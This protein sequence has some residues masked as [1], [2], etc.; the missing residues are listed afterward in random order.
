MSKANMNN[1]ENPLL[2][3]YMDEAEYCRQRGIS[4][5]TAQRERRL[6]VGPPFVPLG[7]RTF[8]RMEAVQAWMREQEIDPKRLR[9]GRR[10]R[11]RS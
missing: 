3:G 5:R 9:K 8:Y 6:R 11:G 4:R 7:Q 2:E 1:A 10:A